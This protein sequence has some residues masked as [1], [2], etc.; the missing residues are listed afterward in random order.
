MHLDILS[1]GFP[2][3]SWASVESGQLQLHG[4]ISSPPNSY[5]IPATFPLELKTSY[6][7][8]VRPRAQGDAAPVAWSNTWSFYVDPG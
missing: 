7:W 8:R 4:A 3:L 2:T 5:A 6:F 1:W